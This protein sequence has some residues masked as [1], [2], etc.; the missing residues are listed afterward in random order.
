MEIEM[1]KSNWVE[2]DWGD[3]EHSICILDCQTGDMERFEVK[4]SSKG[5]AELL[6]RLSA[7]GEVLGVAIETSKHLVVQQL[8]N[9][10]Y[11]IYPINPKLVKSWRENL[12][13]QPS[14]SDKIDAT[15]IAH[16]LSHYHDQLKP[17]F[18]GDAQSRKLAMLCNDEIGFI[19]A[20]TALVNKLQ[21][22][23]K[24]YYPQALKFIDNW[25]AP[26]AWAFVIKYPNPSKFQRATKKGLESF[27]KAHRTGISEKW[28]ERIANRKDEQSWSFDEATS[29]TKEILV[30]HL[31]KQ[32]V[33]L[34]GILKDYRKKIDSLFSDQM[35][36]DLF[37]SL[38]GAGPKLAPRILSFFGEDRTR[39]DSAK[40]LQELS[41]V[42]PVSKVSG[43]KKKKPTV[44]FRRAV[45]HGFRNSMHQFAFCGIKQSSWAK[46]FYDRAKEN[47]QS[48]SLA[49]RNLGVKWLKIIYRMWQTGEKYDEA[50]YLKALIEHGSPLVSYMRQAA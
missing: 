27:L 20:Q 40:G 8:L 14:K 34:K 26:T 41:G 47:G 36:A 12:K 37:Q 23:L 9:A 11:T 5:M 2:L 10:G 38:P 49:L 24:L 3:S 13:V 15:V 29:E 6:G 30:I 21:A 18:P 43:G 39:F 50:R 1:M 7:C 16:G 19:K 28:E 42:V 32:L 31:A 25:A 4:H 44:L 17:F 35:D 22:A 46:A 45:Q 48:N 33:Q